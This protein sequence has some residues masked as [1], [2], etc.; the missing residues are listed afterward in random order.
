MDKLPE[1]YSLPKLHQEETDNLN[2]LIT[3]SEIE[4]VIK[5]APYKQK[6]RTG[7]LHWVILPN[8]QRRTYIYPFKLL[9]KT[10]EEGTLPKSFYEVTITLIPKPE[11]DTTKKKIT[12]QYL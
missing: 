6:S 8:I 11:K 4:S 3:R 1:T 12:G 9:Q 10:E 2:R 7:W 5:K